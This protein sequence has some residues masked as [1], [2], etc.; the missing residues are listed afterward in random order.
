LEVG[1]T[2]GGINSIVNSDKSNSVINSNSSIV[3]ELPTKVYN[4]EVSGTHTYYLGDRFIG[5]VWVH[6][7]CGQVID[8]GLKFYSAKDIRFSQ[9]SIKNGFKG[10]ADDLATTIEGLKSGKINPFDFPPIRILEKD[11]LIFTLDNRRLYVF[12]SVGIPIK[13]VPATAQ[14]IYKE[15]SGPRAYKY[16]TIN[17]GISI[18]VR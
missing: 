6:N 9:D 5:G 16:T 15:F 10:S 17:E 1:N 8:Q 11:G 2:L 7:S 18:L 13:T 14:E 4:F 3:T 12:Q